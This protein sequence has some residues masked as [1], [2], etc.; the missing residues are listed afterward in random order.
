MHWCRRTVLPGGARAGEMAPI[1][2]GGGRNQ[3]RGCV[4]VPAMLEPPPQCEEFGLRGGEIRGGGMDSVLGAEPYRGMGSNVFWSHYC[5]AY[6]R[7]VCDLTAQFLVALIFGAGRLN[8][9]PH[10]RNAAPVFFDRFQIKSRVVLIFTASSPVAAMN[11]VAPL[12][13]SMP[14]ALQRTHSKHCAHNPVLYVF[15]LC[16]PF[17]HPI[18]CATHP[19]H[20]CALSVPINR[21]SRPAALQQS[22]CCLL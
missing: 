9:R 7:L 2:R 13:G 18:M 22:A 17:R 5:D 4:L 10:F 15:R 3:G 19:A 12:C 21:M 6:V 20:H 14:A 11:S 8:S 1:R 16:S